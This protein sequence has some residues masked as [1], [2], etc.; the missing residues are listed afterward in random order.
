MILLAPEHS[1]LRFVAQWSLFL[2]QPAMT[3]EQREGFDRKCQVDEQGNLAETEPG[4]VGWR[5]S[6][7]AKGLHGVDLGG[8]TGGDP[9]C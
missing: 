3:A 7:V 1:R 2:L 4:I 9:A 8:A 6:V 5:T